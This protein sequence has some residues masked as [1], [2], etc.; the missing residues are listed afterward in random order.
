MTWGQMN[1]E[2]AKKQL[3]VVSGAEPTV[4]AGGGWLQGG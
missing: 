1:G 4:G 3:V 2:A